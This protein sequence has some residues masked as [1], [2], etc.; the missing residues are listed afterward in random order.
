MEDLRNR[1]TLAP[2]AG[3]AFIVLALVVDL[4][5]DLQLAGVY[6]TAAVVASIS[7]DPRRTAAVAVAA[8]AAAVASGAWHGTIG[9]P[10][11]TAR[12]VSCVLAGGAAVLAAALADRF[13]QVLRHTT[14]LAH[15]VLDA[16]ATE[17][18]GA[19]TVKAAADGFVG[20][21]ATRLGASSASIYLLDHDGVMRSVTWLGRGGS[22]ADAYSEFRLDADM[23]GAAAAREQR[24]R[25]YPDVAAIEAEFP[26]LAGYYLDRR[27][28]HVLPLV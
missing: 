15:G 20:Q 1:A 28:L 22:Q 10:A 13:R 6:A 11:W 2:L 9:E 5:G 19:R 7:S 8:V 21:A 12:L 4:A 18:T 3:L 27:S 14:L 23:P 24:P 26:D 16:L 25:H 17:L